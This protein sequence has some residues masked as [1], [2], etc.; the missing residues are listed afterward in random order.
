MSVCGNCN[1]DNF[2]SISTCLHNVLF[3][4]IKWKNDPTATGSP[5]WGFTTQKEASSSLILSTFSYLCVSHIL[6]S[7]CFI[8]SI[9]ER[10]KGK[11]HSLSVL[12]FVTVAK[13]ILFM[14]RY[15]IQKKI[16]S[17]QIG[18]WAYCLSVIFTV[19]TTLVF[20]TPCFF[21]FGQ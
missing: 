13:I 12:S 5:L 4:W 15:F 9:K 3:L 11:R 16:N 2:S 6:I 19:V 17:S 18:Q 14:K 20:N 1:N 7:L 21:P 10:K 8:W